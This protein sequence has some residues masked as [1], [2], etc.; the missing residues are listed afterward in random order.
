MFAYFSLTL[1]A[2]WREKEREGERGKLES[3]KEESKTD[4]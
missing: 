3:E 2:V 1:N 4:L